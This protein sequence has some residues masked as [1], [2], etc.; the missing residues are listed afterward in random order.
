MGFLA[1]TRKNA[2]ASI[3]LVRFLSME[4]ESLLVRRRPC[5]TLPSPYSLSRDISRSRLESPLKKI[6]LD[7]HRKDVLTSDFM[8]EPVNEDLQFVVEMTKAIRKGELGWWT[9]EELLRSSGVK[10]LRPYH[11]CEI[12]KQ[13]IGEEAA[14]KLFRWAK[15]QPKYYN[16]TYVYNMMMKTLGDA[17]NFRMMEE[18]HADMAKAKVAKNEI[19][20]MI[21]FQCYFD[22]GEIEKALKFFDVFEH[23]EK[24]AMKHYKYVMHKLVKAGC[25][26]VVPLI[27]KNMIWAG[28]KPDRFAYNVV[29]NSLCKLGKVDEALKYTREMSEKGYPPDVYTYNFVM[30]GI[31]NTTNLEASA[32]VFEEM[33]A[34]KCQPNIVTFNVLLDTF[35]KAGKTAQAADLVRK[36]VSYGCSPGERAFRILMDAFGRSGEVDAAHTLVRDLMKMNFY[37]NSLTL[38]VIMTRLNK[39]GKPEVALELYYDLKAAGGFVHDLITYNIIIDLLGKVGKVDEAW[40]AF[41][42]LKL[43]Q[44]LVP[45]HYTYNT[46]VVRMAKVGRLQACFELIKEMEGRNVSLDRSSYCNLVEAFGRAGHIDQACSMLREMKASGHSPQMNTLQTLVNHARRLNR[47]EV[48]QLLMPELEQAEM[49][50]YRFCAS[51]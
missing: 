12:L 51:S 11:V 29:I 24:P 10:R 31:G 36:M 40:K 25:F 8:W 33:V 22:G 41:E 34:N 6:S 7:S 17:K 48:V 45:D 49:R 5:V 27:F 23:S 28:N 35:C 26:Q 20:Y 14:L 37:P 21:L 39:V 4:A 16:D 1:I 18:L 30:E 15:T 44:R 19:T 50:Q 43:E 2:A 46:I 13:R 47:L 38:N 32:K 9:A 42:E 3:R